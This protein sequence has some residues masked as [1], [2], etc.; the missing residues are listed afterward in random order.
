VPVTPNWATYT[1]M[2]NQLELPPYVVR[3]PSLDAMNIVS[4][5]FG[6]LGEDFDVS[7]DNIRI[8]DVRNMDAGE[9]GQ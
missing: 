1:V 8:A 9:G 7:V 4:I 6:G 3:R 5:N 2:W